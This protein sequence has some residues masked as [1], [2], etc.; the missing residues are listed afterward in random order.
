MP[1]EEIFSK[2][3]KGFIDDSELCFALLQGMLKGLIKD[4]K[5]LKM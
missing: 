5:G 3:K 1:I 4:T 2:I